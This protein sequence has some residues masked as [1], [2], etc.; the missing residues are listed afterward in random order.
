MRLIEECQ[1]LD[2]LEYRKAKQEAQKAT[3]QVKELQAKLDKLNEE[4]QTR[5]EYERD[6]K[7]AIENDL[8]N[9]FCK[10]FERT[11]GKNTGCDYG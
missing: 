3:K 7:I 11:E 2:N 9:T 4:K 6:L 5:K 10:C 1:K 8:K